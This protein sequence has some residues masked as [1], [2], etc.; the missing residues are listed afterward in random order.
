M[1]IA[2]SARQWRVMPNMPSVRVGGKGRALACR[3]M[4]AA[5]A[6]VKLGLGNGSA[7]RAI[8]FLRHLGASVRGRVASCLKNGS[9]GSSVSVVSR[10]LVGRS[11]SC[12]RHQWIASIYRVYRQYR[13]RVLLTLLGRHRNTV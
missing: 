9:Y 8:D 6:S 5:P 7:D 13:V 1:Q 4:S 3:S 12:M 2:R 11:Q 10:V